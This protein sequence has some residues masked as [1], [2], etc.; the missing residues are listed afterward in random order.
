MAP[1]PVTLPLA[2]FLLPLALL[3]GCAG[4]IGA[5]VP[6]AAA[7]SSCSTPADAAR[8]VPDNPTRLAGELTYPIG[9]VH[10]EGPT[11]STIPPPILAATFA[12]ALEQTLQQSGAMT[13]DTLQHEPGHVL[14]AHIGPQSRHGTFTSTTL[15]LTIR[16]TL[17]S[18]L[19]P[20]HPLWEQNITSSG[21]L[22]DWKTDACQ[23]LRNLQERLSRESIQLLLE[24]LPAKRQ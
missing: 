23:R 12:K 19:R 1:T 20:E 3:T 21:E 10:V 22:R 14:L 11:K 15:T 2:V 7:L 18:P 13:P 5:G 16:Y 17:V 8:M 6:F 9:A 24:S 4:N